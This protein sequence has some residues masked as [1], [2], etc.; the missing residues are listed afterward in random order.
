[1]YRMG[2]LYEGG[3]DGE[4]LGM[5]EFVGG[6]GDERGSTVPLLPLYARHRGLGIGIGMGRGMTSLASFTDG[7]M[8]NLRDPRQVNPLTNITHYTPIITHYKPTHPID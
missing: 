7:D 2:D 3:N 8:N 4:G 6:Q 1:M 5:L